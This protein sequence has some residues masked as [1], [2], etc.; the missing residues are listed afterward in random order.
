MADEI[1]SLE[2]Y[3]A[4]EGELKGLLEG[5]GAGTDLVDQHAVSD[6]AKS[7]VAKIGEV[8]DKLRA[9]RQAHPEEF[10]G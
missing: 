5:L 9:Y 10:S 1:Q 7:V 4:L 8:K 2:E 3:R 6:E